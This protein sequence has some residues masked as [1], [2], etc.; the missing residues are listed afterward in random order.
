[1][2]KI[3]PIALVLVALT[4]GV[5]LP[6]PWVAPVTADLSAVL[7]VPLSPLSHAA[8][9]IRLWLRPGDAAVS[10]SVQALE[11]DR[12]H[13]RGLWHAERLRVEELERRV[14]QYQATTGADRGGGALRMI[15][16]DV[17][18]RTA[19]Q[20]G[21]AIKVNVGRRQG[22][23]AGDVAIVGGDALVGRV[24]ADV[25]E[26]S[27][28]VTS[29]AAK[30]TP[31]VDAI[32]VGAA[33]ER[34]RS[35]RTIQVQ[36]VPDGTGALVGDID[37]G[38]STA[39]GDTVR[40]AD[41]SWPRGAQGMRVGRVVE[42]RRKEAQPLRGEVVVVPVIDASTLATMVIKLASGPTP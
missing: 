10:A 22:V 35:P 32:I 16:A 19:T 3:P 6:T 7:W 24:A 37:L 2:R 11:S 41:P 30:G 28:F 4:L 1:M 25:G 15:G 29:I 26:L 13:Y 17:L 36:L 40:V 42:V 5:F 9:A 14:A 34:A 21:I 38:L 27:C 20:G 39:P 23:S 33:E 8:S 18:A 31:R 12:D